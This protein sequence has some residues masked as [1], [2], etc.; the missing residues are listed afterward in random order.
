MAAMVPVIQ[1]RKARDEIKRRILQIVVEQG[2]GLEAS[3]PLRV[4]AVRLGWEPA[5]SEVVYQLVREINADGDFPVLLG[6]GS[7]GVFQVTTIDDRLV[8]SDLAR[9]RARQYLRMHERL[10][11]R[12]VQL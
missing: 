7:E 10:T 1:G 11:G 12:R 6:I 4:I 8:A 5:D 3:L 9:E 2:H